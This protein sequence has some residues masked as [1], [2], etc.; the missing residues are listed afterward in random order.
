MGRPLVPATALRH[1]SPMERMKGKQNRG[2]AKGGTSHTTAKVCTKRMKENKKRKRCTSA[3]GRKYVPS[4]QEEMRED[5]RPE[6]QPNTF[7]APRVRSRPALVHAQPG[8][9]QIVPL[10]LHLVDVAV[11][12]QLA[13]RKGGGEMRA[14][15]NEARSRDD[16]SYYGV[17]DRR[18]RGRSTIIT[19][20]A[21]A[22]TSAT[23]SSDAIL[24][25]SRFASDPS[26]R[27]TR[28]SWHGLESPLR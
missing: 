5:S 8:E 19:K 2:I 4:V 26:S 18:P 11:V 27:Q 24:Q 25:I 13:V 20:Y 23:L 3:K 21:E 7:P 9:G 17:S 22:M 1:L 6:S 15:L 16:A 14:G 28:Q 12:E 10:V